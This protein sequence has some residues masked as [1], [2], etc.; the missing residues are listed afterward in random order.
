MSFPFIGLFFYFIFD[1][2]MDFKFFQWLASIGFTIYDIAYWNNSD[3][4]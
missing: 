1:S 3:P 4:I 2:K